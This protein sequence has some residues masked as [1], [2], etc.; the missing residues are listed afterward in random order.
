MFPIFNP[1][2]MS[3]SAVDLNIS[4]VAVIGLWWSH[5][6]YQHY[7][8]THTL[9]FHI[10]RSINN[11]TT[12]WYY[13]ASLTNVSM[14]ARHAPCASRGSQTLPNIIAPAAP[15]GSKVPWLLRRNESIVPS[16][17]AL[18]N[19]NFS[20]L[21][22]DVTTESQVLNRKN[23]ETLWSFLSEMLTV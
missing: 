19:R 11:V 6:W 22:H 8:N 9:I 5:D 12:Q 13:A 16:H 21:V 20:F 4:T 23:I 10:N 18:E 3:K 15:I 2:H 14:V 7:S 1:D 17:I